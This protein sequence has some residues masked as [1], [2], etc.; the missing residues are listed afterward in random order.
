V[1]VD[2]RLAPEHVFPA[3]AEDCYAA[4]KW[5]AENAASLERTRRG[6]RSA[7]TA[8]VENLAAAVAIDG[9]PIAAAPRSCSSYFSIR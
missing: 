7:V 9:A 5:V 3:A 1:S 8:Q 2:Y 4:T 6:S